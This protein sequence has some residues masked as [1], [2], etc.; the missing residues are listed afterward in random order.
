MFNGKFHIGCERD[1][2]PYSLVALVRMVLHG[3]TVKDAD[4]DACQAALSISQLIKFNIKRILP[5][6]Q[7]HLS[8]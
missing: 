8:M 1:S 2:V 7:H 6:F 3:P 4:E 5:E